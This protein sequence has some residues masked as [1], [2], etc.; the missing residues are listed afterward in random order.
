MDRRSQASLAYRIVTEVLVLVIVASV[1]VWGMVT[2]WSSARL[3]PNLVLYVAIFS[4]V[5]L[6]WWQ[7]SSMYGVGVFRNQVSNILGMVL[8]FNFALMPLWQGLMMGSGEIAGATV[9]NALLPASFAVTGVVLAIL[10]RMG[11]VYQTKHQWRL[12]HH[13]LW[14]TSALLLASV[15]VPATLS[16]QELVPLRPLIWLVIFFVPLAVRRLGVSLVANPARPPA[17]RPA[18]ETSNTHSPSNAYPPGSGH[19][20]GR[21]FQSSNSNDEASSGEHRERRH[22]RRGGHYRRRQGGGRRRM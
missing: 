6:S 14:I 15:L 2:N 10:I 8:A 18:M 16:I 12:V 21:N 9:V 13:S 17:P 20:G 1:V 4:F 11:Q 19:E 5:V 3:V 7:L 22:H